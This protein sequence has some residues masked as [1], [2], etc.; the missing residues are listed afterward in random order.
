[1][2]TLLHEQTGLRIVKN[3]DNQFVVA[4][5]HFTADP[6]K[7]SDAWRKEAQSGMTIAQFQQEYEIDYS[8][9]QGSKVFPEITTRRAEI[10]LQPPW[11]DLSTGLRYWGG[12]DYGAR[13][14]SSF[15]VYTIWDDVTYSIWELYEPCRNIPDFVA[16]MRE[17]PYFSKLRYIAADPKC[18]ARDQQSASTPVSIQDLFFKAGIRNMMK[19]RNDPAGEDAWVAMIRKAWSDEHEPTFKILSCCPAQISEFEKAIYIPQS[20]RQ[21]LTGIYQEVINDKDNHSLDDCKYFMLSR[22]VQQEQAEPSYATMVQ[23]WSA[24]PS[25]PKAAPQRA[26]VR[27]Y[28]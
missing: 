13:N 3:T 24:N 23:R 27:G 2:S 4:S 6:S 10:V 26:S 25:G 21:L 19:G 11:P 17:C 15:H 18:W 1:M 8:A 12:F 28:R 14:P 16:A 9:V 5:L 22:P 20:E 7:R